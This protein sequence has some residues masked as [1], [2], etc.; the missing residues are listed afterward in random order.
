MKLS[1]FRTLGTILLIMGAS[2]VGAE[3]LVVKNPWVRAAPPVAPVLGAF[4]ILENHSDSDISVVEVR[5]SLEV[6]GVG[7]HRTIMADG[8]MSMVPQEF[9]PVAAH[10][11]HCIGTWELAYYADRSKNG[12]R[13]G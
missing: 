8:M 13:N 9:I 12:S 6:D 4:M 5:T 7:M 3:G 2:S 1:I 11:S 10:S